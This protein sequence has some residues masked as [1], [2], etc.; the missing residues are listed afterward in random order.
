MPLLLMSIKDKVDKKCAELDGFDIAAF[1]KTFNDTFTKVN[2]S[3]LTDQSE[4]RKQFNE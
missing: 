3:L 2:R 4:L 1:H